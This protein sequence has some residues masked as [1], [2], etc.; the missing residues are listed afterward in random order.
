MSKRPQNNSVR[1]EFN[2]LE[3]AS[4]PWWARSFEVAAR[5]VEL[6]ILPFR[7]FVL[8][9]E[10]VVAVSFA[11]LVIAGYLWWKGIITDSFVAEQLTVVGA[12][13]IAIIEAS[14]LI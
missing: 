8:A 3:A 5:C 13:L 9:A 6:A 10:A 4:S 1:S 11:S 7:M 14:G 12:R 2:R